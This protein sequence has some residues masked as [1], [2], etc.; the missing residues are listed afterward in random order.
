[1]TVPLSQLIAD[2]LP[3]AGWG[4]LEVKGGSIRLKDDTEIVYIGGSPHVVIHEDKVANI[5]AA[6]PDFFK[7]LDEYLVRKYFNQAEWY[8]RKINPPKPRQ[9]I[10]P[11]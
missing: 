1:M 9:Q 3:I 4:A 8:H 11:K 2:W 10:W 5:S 7:K 6:D